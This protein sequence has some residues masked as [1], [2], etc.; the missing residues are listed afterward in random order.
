MAEGEE[1]AHA[2]ALGVEDS[3]STT[4]G[5]VFAA[6]LRGQSHQ[7]QSG[8]T[9]VR[10]APPGLADL[11]GTLSQDSILGYFQ[12]FP[13]GRKSVANISGSGGLL[14]IEFRLGEE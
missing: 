8:L 7:P 1:A 5:G 9:M 6:S 3:T 12:I 13:P 14:G 2:R 11:A 4:N 10:S